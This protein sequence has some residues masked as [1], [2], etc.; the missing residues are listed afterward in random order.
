M[1]EDRNSDISSDHLIFFS[2]DLL[3]LKLNKFSFH[4]LSSKSGDLT[5]TVGGAT[6]PQRPHRAGPGLGVRSGQDT[7]SGSWV[8]LTCL[9]THLSVDS[10]VPGLTCPW[11]HLGG[12]HLSVDSPGWDSPVCGLTCPWTHLSLD[13]PVPGLTWVGLTCP[14]THLSVDSPVRGLRRI[15]FWRRFPAAGGRRRLA[16]LVAM[17]T[18]RRSELRDAPTHLRGSDHLERSRETGFSEVLE[19]L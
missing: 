7:F 5:V 17:E 11:T 12:T 2:E 19:K 6:R 1:C 16:L 8:G 9:W 4:L 10:P 13:S 15:F 3:N 14:W 18:R